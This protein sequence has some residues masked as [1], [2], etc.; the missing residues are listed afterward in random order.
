MTQ[1]SMFDEAGYDGSSLINLDPGCARYIEHYLNPDEAS[2]LQAA[3]LAQLSWEQPSIKIAGRELPIPRK[4]VWQGEAG[5]HYTYSGKRFEPYPW[6]PHIFKLK[7]RIEAEFSHCFN[8]VLCNLY[9]NG[10]DSVA[11][12]AD[13]EPE[14]GPNPVIASISL[15]AERGFHLKPKVASDSRRHKI[16]LSHGSLL[17]MDK[18]V[19]AYWLHQV[20]KTKTVSAPR[21]NLTFRQIIR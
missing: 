19:Q 14:L 6:H 21:I 16:V 10:Q 15:G 9:R 8:S 12:H 17:L 7:Q 20:P 11:W 4:Q 1:Y 2:T 18:N 3:L 13:D 5:L